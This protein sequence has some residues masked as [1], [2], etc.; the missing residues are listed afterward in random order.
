MPGRGVAPRSP[1]ECP[2]VVVAEP[3]YNNG[4]RTTYSPVSLLEANR[5]PPGPAYLLREC[6]VGPAW[7]DLVLR[8][9]RY[10]AHR[11]VAPSGGS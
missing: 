9:I 11:A 2:A 3:Q 5:L 10:H 8:G 7:D 4:A 6:G 1:P